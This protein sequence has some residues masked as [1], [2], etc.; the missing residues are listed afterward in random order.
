MSILQELRRRARATRY[1]DIPKKQRGPDRRV[2]R[3]HPSLSIAGGPG[4]EL[5]KFALTFGFRFDD[6]G[7]QCKFHAYQMDRLGPVWCR[8]N[9]PIIEK[10]L[11]DELN[12][13]REIG[14][15]SAF[16]G[17]VAQMG[18]PAVI[19]LAINRA[20]S[21]GHV[22][23]IFLVGYP[24]KMGGANTEA[25]HTIRLWKAAGM[26]V[27]LIPTWNCDP[28]DENALANEGFITHHTT[29]DKIREVPNLSDSLTV[30]MCNVHYM[31]IMGALKEIGCKII[32]VNCMTFLFHHERQAFSKWGCPDAMLYQSAH[33]RRALEHGMKSYGYDPT[34]GHLIH[35]AFDPNDFPY[36][37]LSRPNPETDEFVV[38]KLARP[39]ADK[40]PANL[41]SI[42]EK[43]D[44]PHR[45][46][47]IMGVR[48]ETW[49]KIGSLPEWAEAFAPMQLSSADFLSRIHV[50]VAPNGGAGENWSRIGLECMASGV[51]L[52]VPNEW[53]WPEMVIHGETGFLAKDDNELSYYA[54]LLAKDEP[55]R[56]RMA[57]AA[58]KH[59]TENLAAPPVLTSQWENLFHSVYERDAHLFAHS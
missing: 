23:R 38:G 41:W 15:V 37:Y 28:A 31:N 45:R 14:D 24:G 44:H 18:I 27:N 20:E 47:K 35:G 49:L 5:A 48:N 54:T 46:A 32:W 7:C 25:L 39:D 11:T 16:M 33:Q 19:N 13:R 53:G 40:W 55:L 3:I 36:R 51:P 8:H 10:W 4:T 1:A 34:T 52:I 9:M 42:Y 2:T 50:C 43:I 12:R 57:E 26:E 6:P 17:F 56:Q 21:A 58:R 59:L 30:G 22:S 29:P